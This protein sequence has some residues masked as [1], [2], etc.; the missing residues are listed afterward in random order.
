MSASPSPSS[1]PTESAPA[2][3]PRHRF[4]LF[5]VGSNDLNERARANF[6]TIVLPALKRAG[7]AAEQI[8]LQVIDLLAEPAIARE[9][10][11][12]AT[13][14]LVRTEPG[15]ECRVLGTLDEAD[16][17]LAGLGLE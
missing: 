1:F 8:S 3:E 10:R 2:A 4:L 6:E 7:V 15:P 12:I 13:P 14:L 16:R 5:I 9:Y 17:T 11:V